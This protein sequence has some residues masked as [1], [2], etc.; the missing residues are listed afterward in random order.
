[1]VRIPLIFL[2]GVW[3]AASA[4]PV[5][6]SGIE[7]R[8]LG[9]HAT[10]TFAAG[11]AEIAAHDP[12]TQRLF[13]VNG[14][15]HVIDVLDMS[16]PPTHARAIDRRLDPVRRRR[17]QRGRARRRG[18]GGRR[19]REAGSRGIR[20]LLR[21]RRQPAQRRVTVGALPDMVTFTPGRSVACSIANEGEPIDDYTVDPEGS[22][23]VIDL[24]HGIAQARPGRRA[25]GRLPASNGAPPRPERARRS[26]RTR[27]WRRTSSP[28]TSRSPRTRAPLG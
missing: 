24:R 2:A 19:G 3:L 28:S 18:G 23:S 14:A 1:M 9:V 8:P 15:H 6:A 21:R 4:V 7:L 27:R 5:A 22:V 10:G 20:R 11:G 17:Q 13:V 16:R 12:A 25:H 26:A